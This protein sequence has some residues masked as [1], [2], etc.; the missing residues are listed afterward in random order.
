MSRVINN[1]LKKQPSKN[2]II[3]KGDVSYIVLYRHKVPYTC[4]IVD[5]DQLHHLTQ[6]TWG[7]TGR[8]GHDYARTTIH[9]PGKAKI[10][11][12]QHMLIGKKEGFTIDHINRN[13]YDNRIENLQHITL[14]AQQQNRYTHHGRGFYYNKLRKGWFA[15]LGGNW[16]QGIKATFAGPFK[17]EH[18]SKV[19]RKK[20]LLTLRETQRTP[21]PG[22]KRKNH[23]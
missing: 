17:T 1:I 9:T 5:T 2:T 16:R 21:A 13:R 18:Q 19:A 22:Y 6:Y 3:T 15:Y 10:I 14:A 8:D 11:T 12:M 4:A 23:D 7:V 20:L